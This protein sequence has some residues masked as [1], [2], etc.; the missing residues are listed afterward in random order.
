[1]VFGMT[2]GAGRLQ[3]LPR[4]EITTAPPPK[5]DHPFIIL[6]DAGIFSRVLAARALTDAGK[7]ISVAV[8]QQK[9]TIAAPPPGFGR[10]YTNADSR[11]AFLAEAE[12]LEKLGETG[13]GIVLPP[14]GMAYQSQAPGKYLIASLPITFCRKISTFFHPP[15]P[16]C[17]AL[18]QD[19]RDELLLGEQGLPLYAS[20]AQRLL[21]CAKCGGV[22]DGLRTFYAAAAGP[23]LRSRAE[24]R[25]R[26]GPQ[27]YRDFQHL[28]NKAPT[29]RETG[30]SDAPG[31]AQFPC[32][33]CV[34][35]PACYPRR[36]DETQPIPA[37][38]QLYPVAYHEFL[39]LV[40][41]YCEMDFGQLY[42]Y[43]GGQERSRVMARPART[44]DKYAG[45]R[46]H[47]DGWYFFGNAPHER[48][49]LE[50][51]WLKLAAFEQL[52]EGVWRVYESCGRPHLDLHPQ[53]VLAVPGRS[54]RWSFR[55]GL[56]N[57]AAAVPARTGPETDEK[58]RQFLPRANFQHLF[59]S[60]LIRR[61]PY[62]HDE[63]AN[64]TI[65][66][67]ESQGAGVI[68]DV[69]L[70]SEVIR[71]FQLTTDDLLRIT[72]NAPLDKA[73]GLV[74]W[75]VEAKP[76]R[77]GYRL[78]GEASRLRPDVLQ[79]LAAHQEHTLWDCRVNIC[80]N[81]NVRCDLYSLGMML[82]ALLLVN[83][84]QD[85]AEVCRKV[86]EIR[87][88]LTDGAGATDQATP[89][90]VA[91][92][93]FNAILAENQAVFGPESVF[94]RGEDRQS[95]KHDIPAELWLACQKLGLELIADA[96]DYSAAGNAKNGGAQAIKKVLDRLKDLNLWAGGRLFAR[97]AFEREVL[98]AMAR[99][100]QD[101]AGGVSKN[102]SSR[103][104]LES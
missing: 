74:V 14:A 51:L 63:Y 96:P 7:L 10:S 55:V 76:E 19:C 39:A 56:A 22:Q 66:R 46:E 99:D 52:C 95:G 40:R 65:R 77:G 97:G 26:L 104:E 54:S 45:T 67:I 84:R 4:E 21:Y 35:R 91:K 94:F 47:P 11:A 98:A 71:V 34:H 69:H 44:G 82:W 87:T 9:D 37:E 30:V 32:M 64:L 58:Y 2:A 57:P 41:E 61:P 92:T 8:K 86:E 29:D 75:A 59:T 1:M 62:G 23:A 68:L 20:S 17:G 103:R 78:R 38:Q 72:L 5:T 101:V 83:D 102:T 13:E 6:D 33:N 70:A 60:P 42:R 25:L 48:S 93:R 16:L 12:C 18:L 49:A 79:A 85:E 90:A 100:R 53:S 27:L 80:R 88:E 31:I 43:L 73:D 36:S 3:L 81:Y 50:I 28:V 15:C 89:S 24:Q